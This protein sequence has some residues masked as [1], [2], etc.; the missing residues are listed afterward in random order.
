MAASLARAGVHRFSL[1]DHD[2]LFPDNFVRHD[3]DWRDAGRHK[4]DAVASRIQMVNPKAV[5]EKYR[6]NLGGQESGGSTETL[7]EALGQCDLLIDATANA[8]AFN[9]LSAAAV[10][11][12]KP[13]LWAEV[14]SGGVGGSIAR[15]RPG[16]EPDPQAVR[17]AIE[18]WWREQG[19]LTERPLGPY[20]GG[21]D[22]PAIADDSDV[23]VIAAHATR[24]A[25]DTLLARQPSRFPHSV[26][27]IGLAKGLIFSQPFETYPITLDHIAVGVGAQI[28]ET[29]RKAEVDRIIELLKEYQNADSSGTA[30]G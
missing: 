14:Y 11:S 15:C 3:L 18:H 8:A 5:C 17:G 19:S 7:I 4:A 22:I 27:V 16:L 23:T 21:P 1:V 9:Y 25:I 26:Y 30:A 12:E 13:L 28:D 2:I 24:L 10:I 29:E 20:Q 6:Q